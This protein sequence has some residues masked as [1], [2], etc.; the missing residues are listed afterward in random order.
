[1]VSGLCVNLKKNDNEQDLLLLITNRSPFII[2]VK[3]ELLFNITD[4]RSTTASDKSR[5]LIRTLGLVLHDCAIY[6]QVVLP[7]VSITINYDFKSL[8][9]Y[10]IRH[11]KAQTR[12]NQGQVFVERLSIVKNDLLARPAIESDD[13]GARERNV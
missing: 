4:R 7:I 6:V 10:Q 8:G 13:T 11:S 9:G 2:L 12:V 3:L 1:M 5:R